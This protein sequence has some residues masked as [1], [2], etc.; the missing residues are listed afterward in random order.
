MPNGDGSSWHCSAMV[1]LLP[2]RSSRHMSSRA[3]RCLSTWEPCARPVS[4]PSGNAATASCIGQTLQLSGRCAS[5]SDAWIARRGPDEPR[6]PESQGRRHASSP[7]SAASSR[8]ARPVI[9]HQRSDEPR[10][11]ESQG[12][13]PAYSRRS[14]ASTRSARPVI[15]HQRPDEPSRPESHGSRPVYS[16][17]SAASSRRPD[18]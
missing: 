2:A 3:R 8:S 15:A 1:R 18:W 4:S 16:P 9:A 13:R 6:R 17:R 10:R 7:H 14:A 12:R 11:P 5:S